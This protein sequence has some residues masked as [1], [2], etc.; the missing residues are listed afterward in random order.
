MPARFAGS[1]LAAVYH[2]NRAPCMVCS[3]NLNTTVPVRWGRGDG[4]KKYGVGW[5]GWGWLKRACPWCI[6]VT[7]PPFCCCCCCCCYNQK[8]ILARRQSVRVFGVPFSGILL[9][10]DFLIWL[11]LACKLVRNLNV[12]KQLSATA[13]HTIGGRNSMW[14]FW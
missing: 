9:T 4:F 11:S 2:F 8:L 5:G 3:W 7:P 6:R 14:S 12:D 13:H 1:F 10:N